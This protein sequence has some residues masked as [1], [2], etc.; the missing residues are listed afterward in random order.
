MGCVQKAPVTW[1]DR[2]IKQKVAAIDLAYDEYGQEHNQ[3]ILF[4]H[5]FAESKHTW[6]FLINDLSKEY[7]LIMLDL[8]GFGE[9]PKVEDDAYSVYDQAKYVQQFIASKNLKDITIVGR[10]FGGGVSLVLALMQNEGLMPQYIDR[11]VLINS[12]SYKQQLPSM[13]RYL[14]MPIIGYVGIH[15]LNSQWL[16]NEAYKFAFSDDSKIP[17]ESVEYAAKV[18]STPHAKYAY[19]ETVDLLIP[20]D[21][22]SMEM[23]YSTI[24]LPILILWGREDISIRARFAYRLHKD[25]PNSRLIIYSNVGHMPQEEVPHKVSNAIK[26]FIQKDML[27]SKVPKKLPKSLK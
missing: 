12:M 18:L 17:T 20:D 3:T 5:G 16:A 26:R 13:M 10:S 19:M 11:M 22:G 23:R 4:L 15:L 6:R 8:K 14:Q 2:I 9:S 24:T 25:L 1:Q 21:L 27:P 7:H